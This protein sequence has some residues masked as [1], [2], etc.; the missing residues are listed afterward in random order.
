ML[1]SATR[2]PLRPLRIGVASGRR[3]GFT[4]VEIMVALMVFVVGVLA[5]TGSSAIVMTMIGGSQRR[6]I[7]ATVAES[8][9]ERLRALPCTAHANGYAETRGVRETWEIVPLTLA[10]DVTVRVVSPSSGGRI[11]SQTYRTYI[12][13]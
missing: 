7:A 12:P 13:C 5:V 6:T 1:M 4:L 9:F 10:D 11:T 3:A 8:R 2:G